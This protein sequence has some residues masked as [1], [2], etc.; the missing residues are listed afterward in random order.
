MCIL[1]GGAF[2]VL[3]QSECAEACVFVCLSHAK[4]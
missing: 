1:K 2:I 4:S 3:K